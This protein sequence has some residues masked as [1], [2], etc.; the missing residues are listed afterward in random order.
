MDKS[1]TKIESIDFES[2]LHSLAGDPKRDAECTHTTG[3]PF[4]FPTQLRCTTINS[5][6]ISSYFQLHHLNIKP[7]KKIFSS[8]NKVC[9][10]LMVLWSNSSHKLSECTAKRNERFFFLLLPPENRFKRQFLFGVFFF[11]SSIL[12]LSNS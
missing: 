9:N 7:S 4:S 11:F 5:I 6:I 8:S 12:T 1:S 3:K 10:I 2:C